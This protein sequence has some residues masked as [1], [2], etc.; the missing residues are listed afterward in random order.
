MT[1][2]R[3]FVITNHFCNN[4]FSLLQESLTQFFTKT[5][6]ISNFYKISDL[7]W[8]EGLLLDFLQKKITD[9]WVKKFLIYSAYLF[10]E[11]FLFDSVTRV[12]LD[13][14]IWPA[15]K[16]FVF[17]LHNISMLFFLFRIECLHDVDNPLKFLTHHWFGLLFSGQQCL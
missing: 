3:F 4:L 11:R 8:Q 14:L 7:I 13:T 17:D 9:N 16:L 5:H 10:N 6:F 1:F 15:H 12:Y 2:Y